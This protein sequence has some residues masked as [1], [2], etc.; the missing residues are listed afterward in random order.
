MKTLKTWPSPV[1]M[2]E[3]RLLYGGNMDFRLYCVTGHAFLRGRRLED[4][5]G[6]AI[7]GGADCVQLRE[8][9]FN[10]RELLETGRLLRRLTREHGVTF[11]VNDRID[12]ARAVE[13]DGVHLGQNDLPIEVARDILGPGKIVGLSTHNVREAVEAERVGADYIGLGPMRE[14]TTKLDTEP[15]VGPA[16]LAE[17]R[18]HVRLPIV[19]IGGIREQDMAE[20]IRSGAD[21]VA[22]ISALIGADDVEETARRMRRIVDVERGRRG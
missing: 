14:T 10:G 5:I 21:G 15:V 13:A 6:A 2:E 19:A 8:K 4:V 17:V 12:V 18:R 1:W 11:I 3:G 9:D 16:G 7:R 20:I 22:V